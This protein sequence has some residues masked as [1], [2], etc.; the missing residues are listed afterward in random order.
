MIGSLYPVFI[1]A[2]SEGEVIYRWTGYIG[3]GPFLSSL[4]MGLRD[5]TTVKERTARFEK[6]PSFNDAFFLAKY[7]TD[8]GKHLQAVRYY[9]RAADL[10]GSGRTDFSYDI[11]ENTANAVWKEMMPFDE[12]F[13]PADDVL[14][15][16]RKSSNNIIRVVRVMSN[17]ARKFDRTESLEKYLRVGID[18]T[19]K[20]DNKRMSDAHTI[21]TA[22]YALYV[23]GDTAGAV[24]IKKSSL[25]ADWQ[26]DPEKFYDYA[27]WCLERKIMLDEAGY[28][29][30]EAANRAYAGEFKGKILNTLAGI[31]YEQGNND[32]AVRTIEMA[33][34][35]DPENEYYEEQLMKFRGE[36]EK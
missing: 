29:A 14:N 12:I 2:N 22:D 8:A 26:S 30:R 20:S 17:V 9:S 36:A 11:F 6:E 3:S 27:K 28:Y 18:L 31:Y 19:A 15:S 21:F 25:G 1:L 16:P 34:E 32:D 35:Q 5:L 7:M 4:R 13:G 33:I 23:D 10:A 24:G